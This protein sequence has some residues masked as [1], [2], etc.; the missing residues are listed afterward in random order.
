MAKKILDE[1]MWHPKKSL[2]GVEITYVHRGAPGDKV[3]VNAKDIKFEKSFF[4]VKNRSIPYH[5]I[6]EIRKGGELLWRK[7][8]KR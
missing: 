3:S 4:V 2:D 1:L 5:R 7:Q 8:K 6:T